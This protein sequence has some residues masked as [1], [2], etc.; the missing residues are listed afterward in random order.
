MKSIKIS[1]LNNVIS[2]PELMK[3]L[4]FNDID[5]I[6]HKAEVYMGELTCKRPEGKKVVKELTAKK[7]QKLPF[8]EV[9]EKINYK[10]CYR[11][12]LHD[13]SKPLGQYFYYHKVRK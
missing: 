6:Y 8:K 3:Q 2:G 9:F 10:Q 12:E 11:G 13:R 7:L 4:S 1:N 5:V